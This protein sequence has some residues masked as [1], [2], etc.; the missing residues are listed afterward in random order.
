MSEDTRTQRERML[1]G[2]LYL[3]NDPELAAASLRAAELTKA[4]NDSSPADEAEQRRILTDLLGSLG[5]GTVIRP[6]F[7]CDY[8]SHTHVGARGFVNFGLVALDV[9]T[10]HIGDDVQI[11][12]YVQLLTATHPLEPEPRRSKWESAEPVTIEDNVWL[13]GGVIVCPGVTIGA[14]TVV[15]AGAVVTR[16]LPA[17]V[18]AAGVPARAVRSL[19]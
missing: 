1:A 8:G 12:P 13:G 3:A 2:D 10:I 16:N 9:A 15:G 18:L 4:F 5:E 6:P 19:G 14:D 11:G 7:Y 17:G